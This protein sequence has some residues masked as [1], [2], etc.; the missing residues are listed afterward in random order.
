MSEIEVDGKTIKITN[1][2]KPLYPDIGIRKIDYIA[3]LIDLAPY[4]TAH[5]K[6]KALTAIRYPH[7]VGDTSFFYQKRP[8][9]GTPGWVS[10]IKKD[11]EEFV[12]LNSLACLVWLANL[13]VLEFHTPFE[14]TNDT[15]ELTSLVFDLDPSEGQTFEDVT[16]CALIVHETL[17]SLGIESLVK[18]SGA[19]GLQ[20]YIPTRKMT[21][22]EG[23]KI[24]EFFAKYFTGKYP[25]LMTI[26]RIV[27]NRGKKL[28]FD[29]MQMNQ[30][31]SII[32]V[33]SPR[34]VGCG[35]VS[36]PVEWDELKKGISPCQ[37]NLR[38]ASRRLEE[39][40][41]MF[42]ALLSEGMRNPALEE[43]LSK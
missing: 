5:T 30:S 41:D 6:G 9:K 26:E 7:G 15:N 43:I 31:R 11:G 20:V 35:A 36:M 24:N 23:R 17:E 27:K 29:Y 33:Y 34:A 2:E 22:E 14:S 1:P 3:A 12:E 28:Y 16:Q 8:P 18:T 21:F 39:R 32:C 38:N 10:I 42:K 25:K 40:G 4:L 13:A 37:F 19:S